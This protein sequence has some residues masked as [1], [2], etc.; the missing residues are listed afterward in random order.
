MPLFLR[1][2]LAMLIF[3][4][5]LAL[6]YLISFAGTASATVSCFPWTDLRTAFAAQL[7][8]TTVW[9]GETATSGQQVVA[10]GSPA[11]TWTLVVRHP[12][13][14]ACPIS[15]G[16]TWASVDPGQSPALPGE[17]N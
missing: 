15:Y 8:E 10:L 1:S 12:D 17:V 7:G 13:G 6:L 9:V 16:S 11:G 14:T 2:I 3:M 5:V 4:V